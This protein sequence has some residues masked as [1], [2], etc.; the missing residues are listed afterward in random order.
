[1]TWYVLINEFISGVYLL[2]ILVCTSYLHLF[3]SFVR[4]VLRF[5]PGQ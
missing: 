5:Y 3:I 4:V 1:M 2:I